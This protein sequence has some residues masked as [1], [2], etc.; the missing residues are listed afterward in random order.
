MR[1]PVHAL[2]RRLVEGAFLFLL[3]AAWPT[4]AAAQCVCSLPADQQCPTACGTCVLQPVQCTC[5]T[6]C[7]F[8]DAPCS[9]GYTEIGQSSSGCPVFFVSATCRR[10]G[11]QVLSQCATCPANR[12][13]AFCDACPGGVSNACSGHGTC[14]DGISGSGV[15]SCVPGFAGPACQYSNAVTCN[16]HGVATAS[17]ACLCD[18][19]YAGAN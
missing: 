2:V 17:G 15:C 7:A 1:P 16:G 4:S 13:G 8:Q 6:A 12:Y 10:T 3:I 5:A 19:G 9:T 18:N 14:S 11:F